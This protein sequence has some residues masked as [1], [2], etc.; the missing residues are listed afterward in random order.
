MNRK[1]RKEYRKL[2]VPC[3]TFATLAIQ[4]K[5]LLAERE[6]SNAGNARNRK[7]RKEYKELCVHCVTFAAFAIQKITTREVTQGTP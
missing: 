5:Y 1:G 4:K 6:G 3:V 2:C 7:G